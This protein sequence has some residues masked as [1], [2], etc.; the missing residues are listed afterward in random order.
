MTEPRFTPTT[1]WLALPLFVG[2]SG[3]AVAD[4]V[5]GHSPWA[6]LGFLLAAVPLA[7]V[8][9]GRA[10]GLSWLAPPAG[11]LLG[12]ALGLLGLTIP[13]GNDALGLALLG[14]VL[15]GIPLAV[16]AAILRFGRRASL[17]LLVT[18][19]GIVEVL[20]TLAAIDRL[21]REGIALRPVPF[22]IASGQVTYD[23]L[24]GF[25]D[26]FQGS[27]SVS[28]PLQSLGDIGFSVLALLA[29]VGAFVAVFGEGDAAGKRRAVDPQA[30][31]G[32]VAMG[33]VGAGA[34]ELVASREP[35][36]ALLA[37]AVGV[38]AVVV[39]VLFLARPRRGTS[40]RIAE[41]VVPAEPVAVSE[42]DEVTGPG[43]V[44]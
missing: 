7:G 39:L 30:L 38:L 26:L 11:I 43:S 23:Q 14:G 35:K 42:V 27:V 6:A 24:T 40:G 4:G 29:I 9:L 3:W 13:G 18:F 34:F 21:A 5:L 41:P 25:S 22:S 32:P 33:V 12:F 20:T 16:S 17:L 36:F 10:E 8:L 1:S 15:A 19:G 31:L 37:A 28:L 2:Y 44:A